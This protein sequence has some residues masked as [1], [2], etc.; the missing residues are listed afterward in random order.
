MGD[1]HSGRSRLT[2][3]G[4]VKSRLGSSASQKIKLKKRCRIRGTVSKIRETLEFLFSEPNLRRDHFLRE[5]VGSSGTQPIA[6]LTLIQ[7]NNISKV[8]LSAQVIFNL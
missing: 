4:S 8:T 1:D 5:R 2:S 3:T 6:I 7:F